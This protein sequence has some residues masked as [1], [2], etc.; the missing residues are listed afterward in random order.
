MAFVTLKDVAQRAGVSAA[1]VSAS[2]LY[3]LSTYSADSLKY[4]AVADSIINNLSKSYLVAPGT[5]HGF[6]LRSSTGHKPNGSEIDVPIVYADYYF[7]E[8]LLRKQRL[9]NG[10]PVVGGVLTRE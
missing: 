8:A 1:T 2:A 6:L 3:E 10:Q 9:E 4:R 5:M 7:L